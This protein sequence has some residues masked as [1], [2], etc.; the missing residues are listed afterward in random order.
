MIITRVFLIFTAA[1]GAD[2]GKKWTFTIEI[3]HNSNDQ[4]YEHSVIAVTIGED[5][6]NANVIGNS[7]GN[8]LSSAIID[9]LPKGSEWTINAALKGNTLAATEL[10]D[11]KLKHGATF[12]VEFTWTNGPVG[13]AY[14]TQLD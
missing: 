2:A 12:D 3:N 6:V 11:G 1:T 10:D 13:T 9:D 14:P 7:K 8:Q 4:Y 5:R